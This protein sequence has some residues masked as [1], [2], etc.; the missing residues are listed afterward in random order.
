MDLVQFDK[1]A[2]AYFKSGTALEIVSGPGVGKSSAVRATVMKLSK[3]LGEPVGFMAHEASTIESVDVLGF[4]LPVKGSDG[5][6]M[7][8]KFT[9]PPIFP[10]KKSV[11]VFVNG[12]EA[13]GWALENGIP[14]LGVLFID[15]LGQAEQDVQKAFA[16]VILE[17]RMGEY[18]LPAGWRRW[19]ASNRTKDRSGVARRLRHLQNRAKTVQ[20]QPTYKAFELFANNNG[21][22]PILITFAKRFPNLIFKDSVPSEEGPFATPRS[23]VLCGL[24]LNAMCTNKHGAH[25]LPDDEMALE[26]MTGWLG[27]S[28]AIELLSHI[29]MGNDLPEPEEVA[30]HPK[31]TTVPDR[32]DARFVMALQLAHHVTRKTMTAFLEYVERMDV[33]MQVLFC[34]TIT[35]SKPTAM[36]VPAFSEWLASNQELLAAAR[37]T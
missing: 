5:E 16:S 3:T 13:P 27:E 10:T 20:V 26:T 33:E 30:K 37:A 2:P 36:S 11:T 29:R 7:T 35:T 23:L 19:A 21:V 8:S 31:T 9:R 14:E 22:H 28:C 24:D 15:E 4:L 18:R 25:K 12:Q 32:I 34:S 17:G 6:G 1:I